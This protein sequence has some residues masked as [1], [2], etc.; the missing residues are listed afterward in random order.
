MSSTS[1][2]SPYAA[3]RAPSLDG[4]GART[5]LY[6]PTQVALGTF[7]G[8]IVGFVWFLR[9]NFVALGNTDAARNTVL[10]GVALLVV[11]LGIGFALPR[12]GG[13]IGIAI[14]MMALARWIAERH[15]MTKDAIAA[16]S[17]HDF[18]SSWRV[19]GIALACLV[20]SFVIAFGAIMAIT[21]LTAG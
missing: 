11:V 14:A 1:A 13:S 15:Q 2:R 19:F 5:R 10:G 18:H 17:D 16:S 9:E 7:F 8:G 6:T 20:A 21:L 4:T 12:G 3:P